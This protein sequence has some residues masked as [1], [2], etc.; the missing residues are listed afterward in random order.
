G[1]YF[2]VIGTLLYIFKNVGEDE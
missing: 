2:V 1:V